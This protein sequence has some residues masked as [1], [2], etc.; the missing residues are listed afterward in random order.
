M[1]SCQLH[2]YSE[3]TH[4]CTG[5][6]R[7][8]CDDCGTGLSYCGACG[9]K[10]VRLGEEAPEHWVDELFEKASLRAGGNIMFMTPERTI[11]ALW[12]LWLQCWQS[13]RR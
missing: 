4:Y 2:P 5:C 3:A 11:E 1:S 8:L 6:E 12:L 10:V 13:T 9:A 7:P